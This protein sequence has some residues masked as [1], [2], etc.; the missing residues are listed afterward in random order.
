MHASHL[1]RLHLV[2]NTEFEKGLRTS[3]F[4]SLNKDREFI[5]F[6]IKPLSNP[7]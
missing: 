3:H 6:R 1:I 2:E 7:L 5:P 4:E